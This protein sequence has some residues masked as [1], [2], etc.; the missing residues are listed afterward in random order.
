MRKHLSIAAVAAILLTIVSLALSPIFGM[1]IASAQG[2]D[3]SGSTGAQKV[4]KWVVV[5]DP[6]WNQDG[7]CFSTGA[8][9][10]GYNHWP[11]SGETGKWKH[12]PGVLVHVYEETD[13]A[14][15]GLV[16]DNIKFPTIIRKS[17]AE[18]INAPKIDWEKGA[19]NVVLEAV[20]RTEMRDAPDSTSWRSIIQIDIL[21]FA[22]K[23]DR[24]LLL[25]R[26]AEDPYWMY[27]MRV[28]GGPHGNYAS[29][30]RAGWV[31]DADFSPIFP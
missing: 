23:G 30:T 6:C 11:K 8:P 2:P 14:Y 28:I 31:W 27:V 18:E 5:M 17:A 13:E 12:K 4:D 29:P 26:S 3:S 20:R 22:K 15:H 1:G 7:F 21:D 10:P 25:F 16:E 19:K 24:F 9:Q